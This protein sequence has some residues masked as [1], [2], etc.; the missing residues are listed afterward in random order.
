MWQRR[1]QNRQGGLIL[2]IEPID[3]R[4]LNLL[5]GEVA[6]FKKVD[7]IVIKE[8]AAVEEGDM[9]VLLDLLD[10]KQDLLATHED[11]F[12]G[13]ATLALELGVKEGKENPLF[14]QAI[15][16]KTTVA[17]Y[18]VLSTSVAA[19]RDFASQVIEREEIVHAMLESR[20]GEMREKL[21]GIRVGR[22]ALNGYTRFSGGA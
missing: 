14:W 22:N 8:K 1:L 18:V 19:L 20:L 13:W 10:E 16:A 7:D 4:A 3:K 21:R 17:D 12:K 9:E 11:F 2:H 6:F 15:K 5:E